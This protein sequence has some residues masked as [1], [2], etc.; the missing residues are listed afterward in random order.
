MNLLNDKEVSS[1]VCRAYESKTKRKDPKHLNEIA[2]KDNWRIVKASDDWGHW[3]FA[4]ESMGKQSNVWLVMSILPAARHVEADKRFF[5]VC[6][7][8]EESAG[9]DAEK[10]DLVVAAWAYGPKAYWSVFGTP[11]AEPG[12]MDVWVRGFDDWAMQTF[13]RQMRQLGS[14]GTEGPINVL[15]S[16]P[17]GSPLSLLAMADFARLSRSVVRTI[18]MDKAASCGAYMLAI[19]ADEGMRYALPSAT[20]MIHG[21]AAMTGGK[22]PDMEGDVDF[23]ND[24]E[25]RILGQLAE[26]SKLSAE[27]WKRKVRGVEDDGKRELWMNAEQALELGVIDRIITPEEFSEIFG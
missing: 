6:E 22:I 17:G 18:V 27:E 21:V 20:I 23:F 1:L 13:I 5:D 10:W 24:L 14:A 25:D 4:V 16:S 26:R 19:A 8:N 15:I 7:K 9:Y 2:A 12:S 11:D 3:Y